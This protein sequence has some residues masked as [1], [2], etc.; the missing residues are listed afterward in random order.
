MRI[1]YKGGVWKNSEDE[2][3]KAAVMKYG[4]NQWA[5][6]ASLLVRKSA[7]QCKARWFEWLDPAIKKTQWTREEEEKLL[8]LAKIFPTSWRT[9]APMI[10]RTAAQCLEHY[11]KLLDQAQRG[12]D[13]AGPSSAAVVTAQGRVGD[14]DVPAESKPARP[15]PVDMDEDELEML[16][17]ARARLANTKGKKAKRKAREKQLEAAKRLAQLQKRRELKAAGID[18][19]PRRKNR[20]VTDYATEIPFER[21]PVPGF[22]DITAEDE[23]VAKES[24]SKNQIGKLLQK[25]KGKGEEEREEELRKKDSEK[26]KRLEATNLPAALGLNKK[27]YAPPTPA[28]KKARLSLPAPQV[29]DFDLEN[30]AKQGAS[31]LRENGNASGAESAT[32]SQTQEGEYGRGSALDDPAQTAAEPWAA[33]RRRHLQTIV[34]LKSAQTPLRGGKNNPLPQLGLQSGVTPMRSTLPTPNP[35]ATPLSTTHDSYSSSK[36]AQLAQAKRE[37]LKSLKATVRKGISGLPQ[38]ENEYEI[39]IDESA[40]DES[41][42]KPNDGTD[43]AEDAEEVQLRKKSR[44][45]KEIEE[46]KRNLLSSAAR[47]KLPIPCLERN[48][49]KETNAG[50]YLVQRDASAHEILRKYNNSTQDT[51]T[52]LKCLRTLKTADPLHDQHLKSARALIKEQMKKDEKAGLQ[53]EALIYSELRARQISSVKRTPTWT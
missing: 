19:K 3:L 4:K 22:Y 12:P 31:A 17:E 7:K 45:E 46:Q 53:M 49:D 51:S 8:H 52:T 14:A 39:E 44:Y 43:I 20:K 6:I 9:I 47:R 34:N 29:S 36:G 1:Q 24:D 48:G 13:E 41:T 21:A 18:L 10:G 38:P 11:E 37:K 28:L 40:L 25:Y 26:R 35:L 50:L 15:D 23:R 16:S 27:N 5:R 32:M 33:I 42:E 30:I 2:I